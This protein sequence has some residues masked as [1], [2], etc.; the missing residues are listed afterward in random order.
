MMAKLT[1]ERNANPPLKSHFFLESSI[2][3]VPHTGSR[4]ATHSSGPQIFPRASAAMM[5]RNAMCDGVCLT[6]VTGPVRRNENTLI[7]C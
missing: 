2:F 5:Q 4:L 3:S 6:A 1:L 7:R